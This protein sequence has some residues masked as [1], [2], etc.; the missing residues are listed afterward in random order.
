MP[1][2]RIEQCFQSLA[3]ANK[4]AFIAFI[5]AGDPDI[6]TSYQLLIGLVEAGVDIIELGMPFSDP[7]ADGVAIQNASQR[8]L[9]AGMTLAKTLDLVRRFRQQDSQT[10]IV[11]MG[12]YNPIYIYGVPQFLTD[13][14]SAGVDGLI[15]VD[16]P[17]EEDEEVCL[18]ALKAGLNFIHLVAPTTHDKRLPLVLANTSGFVYYVS[19]TGITG[20]DAA[21][22][23]LVAESV[24]RL[25]T[26]TNLP[27]VVG[28]GI[29]TPE[30][31][32]LFARFADG[33]V[34][35]SALVEAISHTLDEAGQATETTL[36][37]P[38]ALARALALSVAQDM[39]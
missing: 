26:H 37:Q 6:E 17:P 34:V 14:Q 31:M 32:R 29:K 13:A 24:A 27:I 36:S 16:L 8:A 30:Q 38:L 7:M 23:N 18:P 3:K 20:A 22:E 1:Q 2:T 35:G 15:I 19:I 11:L 9:K 39:K 4:T 28:F 21:D 25:K 12:Y 5:T 10:P 33:V